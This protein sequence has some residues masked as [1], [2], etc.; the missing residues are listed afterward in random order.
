MKI[1]KDSGVTLEK[2]PAKE[3]GKASGKSPEHSGHGGHG[4]HSGH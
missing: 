2:T 3:K 1:L 4:G